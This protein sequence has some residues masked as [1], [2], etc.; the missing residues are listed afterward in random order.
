MRS[1]RCSVNSN[2]EEADSVTWLTFTLDGCEYKV[3]LD[4][5]SIAEAREIKRYTGVTLGTLAMLAAG[6]VD[7]DAVAALVSLAK[8]RAGED[9]DWAEIDQI[10]VVA[11][12][13]TMSVSDD[14][15]DTPEP[16]AD[17]PQA[18][19]NG[20]S[21]VRRTRKPPVKKP[22]TQEQESTPAT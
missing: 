3:T 15:A 11:L 6:V 4:R 22:L 13:K 18:A 7:A 21:P 10:D 5:L 2:A 12:L 17:K 19:T 16:A 14:E 1:T 8:R 9:I 20:K